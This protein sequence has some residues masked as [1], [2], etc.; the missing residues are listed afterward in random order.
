[1][2]ELNQQGTTII[3]TSHHLSEAEAFC[4]S[5]S[6]LDHGK[7]IVEGSLKALM[8]EHETQNLKDLFLR[9]TGE[10]LRD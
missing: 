2:K 7:V 8:K 5:I 3:Y 10:E 9:F 1:L 4:N 6:L